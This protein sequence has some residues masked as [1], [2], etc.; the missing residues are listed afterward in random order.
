MY[1]MSKG[2]ESKSTYSSRFTLALRGR[3]KH[4]I[5]QNTPHCECTTFV[6]L[7]GVLGGGGSGG[8]LGKNLREMAVET[9]VLGVFQCRR[10]YEFH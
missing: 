7:G 1:M 5:P 9:L 3:T 6:K 4:T 8:V 10:A 2:L